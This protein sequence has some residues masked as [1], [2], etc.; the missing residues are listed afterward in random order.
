MGRAK[1]HT[2]QILVHDQ[3]VFVGLFYQAAWSA[4]QIEPQAVSF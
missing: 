3:A 1:K 2:E 4:V